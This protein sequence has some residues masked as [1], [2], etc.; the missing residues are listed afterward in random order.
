M[1]EEI[2]AVVQSQNGMRAINPR[3][4][5]GGFEKISAGKCGT[6]EYIPREEL[7]VINAREYEAALQRVRDMEERL[8]V[9]EE[10][11]LCDQM[12]AVSNDDGL[13]INDDESKGTDERRSKSKKESFLDSAINSFTW[14]FRDDE[15]SNEKPVKKSD[16]NCV[17]S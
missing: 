11:K 13:L 10:K 3:Y 5:N 6:V 8:R 16:D 17:I 2:W 12:K 4:L 9:L 14:F 7:M 1:V 15:K